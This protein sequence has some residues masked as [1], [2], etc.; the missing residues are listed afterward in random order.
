MPVL[1]DSL[2]DISYVVD[3]FFHGYLCPEIFWIEFFL[4][5]YFGK[6]CFC[7]GSVGPTS[8]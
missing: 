3:E 4:F 7:F 6:R 1:I 5:E 2:I 8:L